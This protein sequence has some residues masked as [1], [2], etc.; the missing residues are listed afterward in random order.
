MLTPGRYVEA[1]EADDDDE[2]F[3]EKMQRLTKQSNEQLAESAKLEKVIR[4]NLKGLGCNGK[5]KQRSYAHADSICVAAGR[6]EESHPDSA[7]ASH[8][9]SQLR[10]G[11]TVLGHRADD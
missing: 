1:E 3:D 10:A 7:N 2:P 4:K 9:G 11:P 5:E 8:V 6:C